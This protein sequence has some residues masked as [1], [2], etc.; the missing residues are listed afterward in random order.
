MTS[1]RTGGVVAQLVRPPLQDALAT[2][3]EVLAT[4]ALAFN[5][6]R[7]PAPP[8]SRPGPVRGR[9]EWISNLIRPYIARAR[10]AG[11]LAPRLT[12]DQAVE[13]AVL[14]LMVIEILPGSASLDLTDPRGRACL[15]RTDLSGIAAP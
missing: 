4:T 7:A 14:V 5:V 1:R 9:H 12:E 13:W 3:A 6:P 8:R 2:I 15:R 10:Q 11:E